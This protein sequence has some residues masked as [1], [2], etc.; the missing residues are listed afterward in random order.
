MECHDTLFG[1]FRLVDGPYHL[2]ERMK[3]LLKLSM[4]RLIRKET[5]TTID[6]YEAVRIAYTDNEYMRKYIDSR[7]KNIEEINKRL[8]QCGSL[9]R[10]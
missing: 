3:R 7:T 5:E 6:F 9:H 4:I 2:T 1:P 8:D 10:E